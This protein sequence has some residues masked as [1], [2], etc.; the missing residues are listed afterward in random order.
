MNAS[1]EFIDPVL[2]DLDAAADLGDLG[3][4]ELAS[5]QHDLDGDGVLDTV[6]LSNDDALLV[7]TDADLDGAIDHLTIVDR[8]GDFSAWEFR[9]FGG[10]EARWERTDHGKLD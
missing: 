6:T 3:T 5:P 9:H 4:V 8:D 2:A 7:A 10:D 1:H